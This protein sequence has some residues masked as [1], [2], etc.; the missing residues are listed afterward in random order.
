MESV[1]FQTV[2]ERNCLSKKKKILAQLDFNQEESK[3]ELTA[4]TIWKKLQMNLRF[5]ILK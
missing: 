4:Q 1:Q 3:V 2:G 5:K